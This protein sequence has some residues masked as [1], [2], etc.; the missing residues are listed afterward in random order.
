V[1]GG[2]QAAR[3]AVARAEEGSKGVTGAGV[4]KRMRRS[5]AGGRRAEQGP[6]FARKKKRGEEVRGT[7]LR[8]LESSRTS[9]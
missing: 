2:R 7:S 5:S 9:R 1:R 8:F 4:K 3:D 6:M